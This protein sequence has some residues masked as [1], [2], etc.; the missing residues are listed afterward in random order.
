MLAGPPAI[1]TTMDATNAPG[2]DDASSAELAALAHRVDAL[3]GQVDAL[4]A[5]IAL[6][7]AEI[8]VSATAKPA[9]D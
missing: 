7:C 8:G 6:L 1:E 3:Q 2:Y 9:I 4:K 5:Q